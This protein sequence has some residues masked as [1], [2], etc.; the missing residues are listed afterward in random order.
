MPASQMVGGGLSIIV[1]DLSLADLDEAVAI[2][3]RGEG[4][5]GTSVPHLLEPRRLRSRLLPFIE[6]EAHG[7]W[8]ATIA[9]RS[10]AA[11]LL[12]FLHSNR[13]RD[14]LEPTD[15]LG[16]L[17]PSLFPPS[18]DFVQIFDLW[19]ASEFRRLGMASALKDR[20]ERYAESRNIAMLYTVTESDNEPARSLN[21]KLGY[22]EL[23][24]GPM[25]DEVPRTALAKYLG[26][27]LRVPLPV[28]GIESS[29]T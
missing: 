17:K 19:I 2:L 10:D 23:Y 14:V 15:V 29:G 8:K 6:S 25:W 5:T 22:V 20:L 21:K 3:S 1:T 7:A 12:F 4:Y 28:R 13:L 27:G 26:A 11:G 24:T 9:G 16:K 18:G